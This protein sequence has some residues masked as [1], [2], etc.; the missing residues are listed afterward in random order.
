MTQITI[1]DDSYFNSYLDLDNLVMY[2]KANNWYIA[3]EKY[4]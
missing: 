1:G 3:E 4:N 2:E